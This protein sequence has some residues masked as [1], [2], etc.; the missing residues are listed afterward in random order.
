MRALVTGV[1]AGIGGAICTEIAGNIKHGAAA[2]AICVRR[3]TDYIN[4]LVLDLEGTGANVV[5]L[6]GDLKDPSAPARLVAEAVAAFGGLDSLISNAGGVDPGPLMD[7]TIERFDNLMRL[8]CIATLLLAQ[9]AYPHL[10]SSRGT[11]VAVSSAAGVVPA[12]GTAAY[13]PSKAALSMLCRQLALEWADDG[14]RVNVVSPGLT[15][16]P[17]NEQVFQNEEILK[18]RLALIPIHRIGE[19]F[20]IARAVWYF[21]S[22]D[23]HYSTGI[24]LLVDGGLCSSILSH[25]PGAPRPKS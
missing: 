20:D 18:R 13:G 5:V 23:N 1:S 8:N 12:A 14:I 16:T 6:Y 17:I 4:Q 19:P 25:I 3:R 9:A 7:L 21:A 10:K 2:L 24:D 15:R 22:P 11:M